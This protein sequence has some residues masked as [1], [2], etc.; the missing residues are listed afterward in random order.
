MKI[1]IIFVFLVTCA[2]AASVLF[3][4]AEEIFKI[5]RRE[6]EKRVVSRQPLITM[7]H[8]PNDHP[9]YKYKLLWG[10]KICAFCIWEIQQGEGLNHRQLK[11]RSCRTCDQMRWEEKYF[12][13]QAVDKCII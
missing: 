9:I 1:L 10:E 7:K 13:K 11:C 6:I 8:A 4:V 3:N 2:I 12:R 5:L